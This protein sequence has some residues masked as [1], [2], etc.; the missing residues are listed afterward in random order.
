MAPGAGILGIKGPPDLLLRV[1]PGQILR[2]RG[3]KNKS[4]KTSD[5]QVCVKFFFHFWKI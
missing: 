5:Y 1:I 2:A 3:H 4:P